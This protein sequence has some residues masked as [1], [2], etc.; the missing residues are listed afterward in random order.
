MKNSFYSI[1]GLIIM[2]AT[3]ITFIGGILVC[4]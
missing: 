3:S 4:A 2:V 1:A